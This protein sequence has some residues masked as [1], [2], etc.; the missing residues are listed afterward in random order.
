MS[1]KIDPKEAGRRLQQA[2][3]AAGLTQEQAATQLA[4]KRTELSELENG[5][6]VPGWTRL[7]WMIET[8]GLDYRILFPEFTK[9]SAKIPKKSFDFK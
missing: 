4:M 8:L 7:L 2:R 9:K 3:V 6:R 1:D 5:R